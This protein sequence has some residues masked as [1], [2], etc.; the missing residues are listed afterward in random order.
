[1]ADEVRQLAALLRS[2][3]PSRTRWDKNCRVDVTTSERSEG[4]LAH[5]FISYVHQNRDLVYRLA[6][7]LKNH[8]V[9]VWLDRDDIQPGTR[10][11]MEIKN[12]IKQGKFFIA[13]FSREYDEKDRTFMSE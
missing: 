1:M 12:A 11:R 6:R 13:C 10:W 8:G 4:P 7:E 2:I 5:V 3:C 9:S